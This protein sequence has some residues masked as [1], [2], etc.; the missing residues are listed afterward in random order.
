LWLTYARSSR[1]YVNRS[2]ASDSA[3]GTEFLLPGTGTSVSSDD[4]SAVVAFGNKIGVAWSNQNTGAY[5]WAVHND[6][7]AD[8]TWQPVTIIAQGS[9]LSDD[10]LNFAVKQGDP[11]GDVYLVAKT[12]LEDVSSGSSPEP[13]VILF[14]LKSN[15]TWSQHVVGQIVDDHTRPIV[16]LDSQNRR[17]YVFMTAP[18]SGGKIYYK[19]AS[20][21]N[22]SFPSGRGTEII[23][24]SSDTT[25]NNVTSTRQNVT[26][27][28]GLIVVASDNNTD[29]YLHGRLLK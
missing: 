4:I 6:R 11:A 3:W 16:V 25:I 8:N 27:S 5:Y 15:G 17:A 18:V 23:F 9:N 28:M 10:H 12:S 24:S 2:L 29:F 20:L 13:Q 22:L 14:V 7:D 21:D 26:P 1:I 19:S